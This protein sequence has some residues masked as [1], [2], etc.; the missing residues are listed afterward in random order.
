M[1]QHSHHPGF[2]EETIQQF[3]VIVKLLVQ[4]LHGYRPLQGGM[5]AQINVGHTPRDEQHLYSDF[6][7]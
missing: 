5:H 6:S 7:Q 3:R 4:D 1:A 2:A